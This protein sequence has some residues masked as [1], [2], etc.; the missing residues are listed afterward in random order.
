MIDTKVALA[1]ARASD[2][3]IKNQMPDK[4]GRTMSVRPRLRRPSL[5]RLQVL[6]FL[7]LWLAYGAAINSDNLSKFNLQQIGVAAIVERHQFYLEGS[8]VPELFPQ[9]DVFLF[10]GHKYAAKQPGQFMAGAVVY[11]VLSKTRTAVQRQ[12]PADLCVGHFFH[13]VVR[14]GVIRGRSFQDRSQAGK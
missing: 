6:L 11:W 3:D 5:A 1:H 14:A 4:A 2:T 9:G 7:F 13:D 12:L 8:D 10:Q